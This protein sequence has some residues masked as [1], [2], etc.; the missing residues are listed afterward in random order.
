MMK[1]SN[2]IVRYA[3]MFTLICVML[4]GFAAVSFSKPVVADEVTAA[5][6]AQHYVPNTCMLENVHDNGDSYTA[7]FAS[8]EVGMSMV[9]DVT[10]DK[11]TQEVSAMQMNVNGVKATSTSYQD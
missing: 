4:I 9:Y 8:D 10:I 11:S 7:R 2:K 5:Q 3:T 6:A 1:S